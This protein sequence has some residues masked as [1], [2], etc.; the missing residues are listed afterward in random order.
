MPSSYQPSLAGMPFSKIH[1]PYISERPPKRNCAQGLSAWHRLDVPPF[2]THL[3]RHA[4]R[5]HA[6]LS[7]PF[8][9]GRPLN[10][11]HINSLIGITHS[12]LIRSCRPASFHSKPRPNRKSELFMIFIFICGRRRGFAVFQ[13]EP[14]MKD[15][16]KVLTLS[17]S[18]RSAATS[19]SSRCQRPGR[20]PRDCPRRAASAS[21]RPC[22]NAS[23]RLP[24]GIGRRRAPSKNS[25]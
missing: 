4:L 11:F 2:I 17:P 9:D 24:F 14:A 21:G 16:D 12:S 5:G 8:H 15:G 3:G 10:G 22:R 23:R 7:A 18:F 20:P 19:T 1:P 13:R 25:Y 6:I